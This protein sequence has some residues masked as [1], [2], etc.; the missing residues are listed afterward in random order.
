MI[1]QLWCMTQ[2]I[3]KKKCSLQNFE[4]K[5]ITF[6][7]ALNNENSYQNLSDLGENLKKKKQNW[8]ITRCVFL[9]IPNIINIFQKC[10]STWVEV[11]MLNKIFEKIL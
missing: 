2:A 6:K 5:K 10:Q 4:G 1:E 11:G 9:N 8:C 3:F 7:I